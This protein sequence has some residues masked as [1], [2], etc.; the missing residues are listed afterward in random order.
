MIVETGDLLEY[1]AQRL[2]RITEVATFTDRVTDIVRNAGFEYFAYANFKRGQSGFE[3][4]PVVS[5]FP[6]AWVSRYVARNYGA[7][8]PVVE[9]ALA[10][11]YPFSWTPG[12]LTPPQRPDVE[13]FF[14]EASSFG[15]GCGYT[16]P[17][18][19][20]QNRIS[21]FSFAANGRAEDLRQII[22]DRGDALSMLGIYIHN[23][24]T[25]L[26]T[27]ADV[28]TPQISG[29]EIECLKWAAAGKTAWETGRILN[30]SEHTVYFHWA[31]IK[32]K[33]GVGDIKQAIIV[34]IQKGL[35]SFAET[36]ESY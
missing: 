17:I 33:L 23:T 16:V 14:G 8:D 15:I 36:C 31:N 24:L 9:R 30:I 1:A 7:V 13:Q 21:I 6:T 20:G 4:G 10:T 32:R 28:A 29:R 18:F 11:P 5:N 25:M 27:N 34:A 3:V 22:E 35:I 19:A 26:P 2:N 12:E